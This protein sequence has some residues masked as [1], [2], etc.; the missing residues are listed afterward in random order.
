MT[1]RARKQPDRRSPKQGARTGRGTRNE[2]R[3]PGVVLRALMALG[4]LAA[5]HPTAVGGGAAF[6]V[7]FSFV[8]ANAL[9]YQPGGHPSPFLKTRNGMNTLG[10]F[11]QRDPPKDVTTFLIERE[12]E[13]EG[14]AEDGSRLVLDIQKELA[15]Q[16]YYAGDT[17]GMPGAQTTAA[18]RAFE[19]KRGVRAT[20]E[21]SRDLLYALRSTAPAVTEIVPSERP[22][23]DAKKP[24]TPTKVEDPV[25]AAILSAEADPGLTASVTR[26]APSEMV[27]KI[28]KGLSNIAYSD[29]TVDGVA[30]ERTRAAIRHFEKHYRLPETGEP[31]EKVL[32]KLREIGAL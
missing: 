25:A 22:F 23:E 26:A 24:Q 14:D 1:A 16:G 5:R 27:M 15:R 28:Q 13:A 9:W 32:V 6:A 4:S 31:N 8:A 12:G 19:E 29:V 21:A 10:F 30:G 2:A 17:D 20:G 18:I 11:A 7:V 3:G